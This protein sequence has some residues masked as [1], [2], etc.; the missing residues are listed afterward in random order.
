MWSK[1]QVHAIHID[2]TEVNDCFI[3]H[4]IEIYLRLL[5]GNLVLSLCLSLLILSDN[6]LQGW[7]IVFVD[8]YKHI[9]V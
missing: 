4:Y 2:H 5:L 7:N 8:K 6:E 1:S 3:V 9:C